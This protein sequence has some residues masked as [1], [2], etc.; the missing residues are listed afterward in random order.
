MIEILLVDNNRGHVLL[1]KECLNSGYRVSVTVVNDGEEALELLASE[2]YRPQLVLLELKIPRLQGD[3]VLRRIR[4]RCPQLPVVVLSASK[5]QEDVSLAYASGANMYAE[6]PVEL[7][8]FRKTIHGIA[9]L[10]VAPM[11][12]A[13]AAHA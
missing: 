11:L 4:R 13:R 10:W 6:K 1:V 9:R 5:S 12:I 2:L 7:D 3:E 8:E